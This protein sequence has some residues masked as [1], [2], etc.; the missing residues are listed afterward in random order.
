[1]NVAQTILQQLG[2]GRFLA[3]TGA[4]NLV[5]EGDG[6]SMQLPRNSSGANRLTIKLEDSDTYR[7]KFWKLHK[8]QPVDL[9]EHAGIYCDQL[10]PLFTETTGFDTNLGAIIRR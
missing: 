10:Q 8:L 6:L 2:G 5:N 9:V 1:M 3:M 7:M 4:R